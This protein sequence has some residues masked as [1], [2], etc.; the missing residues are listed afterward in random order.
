MQLTTPGW[1]TWYTK[2]DQYSQAEAARPTSRRCAASTRTAA[3]SSSTSNRRRCRSRRTRKTSTSRSTSSR[4]RS[5]RSATCGSPATSWCPRPSCAQLLQLQPGDVY[6]R[7]KLQADGQGH[8]RP[9][10]RRG[11]RVRQRQR[12]SRDRPRQARSRRSRSSSTPGRRVYVRRINISGNARTRDEVIRR[13]MRQL[14][15]AWYDG[16][17]I[18]RSKVR[19]RRLG[20]LRRRQH[21]DPAGAGHDRPGRRRRH[22]HRA[23]HRQ[24]CYAGVGYSS[25]DGDRV[26][27]VGV[28]AEHL[29]HRQRARRRRSTP[30]RSTATSRS[31]SPSPTG[32]STASR[33]RSRSTTRTVDPTSLSVSHYASST[34]R[35][36]D[37]L[38]RADH[39]DRQRSTWASA[40]SRP[41]ITLFDNSPPAYIALRRRVRL[42]PPTAT[43]SRR[44][45]ARHPR[46]HPLSHARAACR[47]CWSRSGCRSAT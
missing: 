43:S 28:A 46:R 17:R 29:R 31:R 38:R 12:G 4:A 40:S 27:R 16:P 39:R 25:S 44:L 26:Q 45:V 41:S 21:R 20:L 32:R 9:A 33:G 24:R 8:Q 1:L 18:E 47:A 35:R 37:R 14:E 6:S 11:L 2:N 42:R 34:L 5:S 13:E 15:S 36:G 3:T 30:A 7:E 23:Q 10:G 22:R 19:I